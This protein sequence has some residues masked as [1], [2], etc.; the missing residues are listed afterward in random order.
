MTREVR[1][2]ADSV[3]TA[4]SPRERRDAENLDLFSHNV[5]TVRHSH[6]GF[7]TNR[8]HLCK[9]GRQGLGTKADIVEQCLAVHSALRGR[10][11]FPNSTVYQASL[12]SYFS[13][14]ENSVQPQCIISPQTTQDVAM[15]VQILTAKNHMANLPSSSC[16]F[17]IRSGGHTYFAG[18]ANEPGGVT[19]DLSG[20]HDITLDV[21]SG[22]VSVG[23]GASWGSVF[24]ELSAA[25]LGVNG[26]RSGGVGVGGLTLGGGISFFGPRYGWTCDTVTNLEVVLGNG[27]I[28]NANA[29]EHAELLWALRGG[30]NNFG[31]VTRVQLKTFQQGDLWG[32]QVVRNITTSDEQI[33]A[34]AN[35]SDPDAYDEYASLITTWAYDGSA[36]LSVIVNNMEYT[37]PVAD[38]PAFHTLA[39]MPSLSSTQRITNI[40][41]LLSETDRGNPEGRRQGSATVTIDATVGAIAAAVG[42]WNASVPQIRNVSGIIW[43]LIMDI[44]PPQL[45]ARHAEA[46]ALGLED[47]HNKTLIILQL[48]ATWD[49]ASDDDTIEVARKAVVEAVH[50]DVGAVGGLDAFSYINYAAVW[51]TPFLG[52]GRASVERLRKVQQEYDPHGVFTDLV[53][54]GFKLPRG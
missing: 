43:A 8:G 24:S 29:A 52:Y 2:P 19:I 47:R 26:G 40:T 22:L 42:A 54:G 39:N 20:L 10:V 18:A 16:S 36:D 9:F 50:R 3:L 30:T 15:A 33:L 17:A 23:S 27:T 31:I 45:Y 4:F 44:L 49:L 38:P 12:E 7:N 53:P 28:V 46:N 6:G 32:G 37:K 34:I 11:S 41:S 13:A 25:N 1:G 48:T 21:S 14:Q 51:Q 5:S 35:F